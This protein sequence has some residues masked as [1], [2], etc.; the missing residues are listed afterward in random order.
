M[1]K[2]FQ[3]NKFILRPFKLNDAENLQKYLN[4]PNV[5][6][7]LS[8]VPYPYTL[9]MANDWLSKVVERNKMENPS[10]RNFCIEINDIASGGISLESEMPHKAII[11]YWLAED[12]WKKGIMSEAVKLISDY[13]I[14]ELN[15][16]RLEAHVLEYNPASKRVLEKAAFSQ[17]AFIKNYIK[18][19]GKLIDSFQMSRI[20]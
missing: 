19:D 12:Y 10:T 16:D 17:E 4:N 6:H 18:K 15:F 14:S 7:N 20:K 2:I 8:R 1:Q 3:T 5:A 11:G 9:E 13:A